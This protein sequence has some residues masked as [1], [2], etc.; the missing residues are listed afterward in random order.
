MRAK[1]KGS[2]L[3]EVLV[4]LALIMIG[5]MSLAMV[6]RETSFMQQQILWRWQ[7][8]QWLDALTA[9]DPSLAQTLPSTPS[10]WC[11]EQLPTMDCSQ[12]SCDLQALQEWQRQ[13]LCHAMYEELSEVAVVV[14]SCGSSLC[15]SLANTLAR[16]QQCEFD[17][18]HCAMR[19]L[20]GG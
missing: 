18:A 12:Q 19:E 17:D 1:N 7:A 3:V 4:A 15:L 16:A 2:S 20:R 6:Q 8:N 11:T 10:L 9:V 13:R 5:G 14:K